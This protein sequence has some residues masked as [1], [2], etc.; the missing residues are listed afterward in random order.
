[1]WGGISTADPSTYPAWLFCCYRSRKVLLYLCHSLHQCFL[2]HLGSLTGQPV[3]E[4]KFISSFGESFTWRKKKSAPK[5]ELQVTKIRNPRIKC[6]YAYCRHMIWNI[7]AFNPVGSQAS[8]ILCKNDL[9]PHLH[10]IW[11]LSEALG[12]LQSNWP[13]DSSCLEHFS[14]PF[15]SA[16]KLNA[17]FPAFLSNQDT[18]QL[19]SRPR[20]CSADYLLSCLRKCWMMET[21]K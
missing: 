17:E 14:S 9:S 5:V 7:Q 11:M 2:P 12:S 13:F 20:L 16:A 10:T 21:W 19:Q 8:N 18:E 15:S 4:L 3:S 6:F 1:M